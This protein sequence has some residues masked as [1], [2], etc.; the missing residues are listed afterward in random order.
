[1]KAIG[2]FG[3]IIFLAI[4]VYWI[5]F[6]SGGGEKLVVDL[7]IAFGKPEGGQVSMD[8]VLGVVLANRARKQDPTTNYKSEDG[9]IRAH[10]VVTSSKGQTVPL[11]RQT[12]S[13][14]VKP[15]EVAQMVGT[16]EYFVAGRLKAGESYT[17][18]FFEVPGASP[19]RC[20]F[21]APDQAQKV[22]IYRF[23]P[24]GAK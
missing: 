4:M 10:F 3:V 17:F 6:S 16:E 22:K 1:M 15:H 21:T 23:E 24:V 7:P 9:W 11:A 5:S 12:S 18:D 19:Y 2:G 14:L 8:V 13:R 20:Q